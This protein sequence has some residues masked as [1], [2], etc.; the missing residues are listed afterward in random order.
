M[1][2]PRLP[3]RAAAGRADLLRIYGALGAAALE[4]AAAELHYERPAA[5]ERPAPGAAAPPQ[6]R[7][8]GGPPAGTPPPLPERPASLPRARFFRVVEHRARSAP[9]G[10]GG[11]PPPA[12]LAGAELLDGDRLPA[13]APPPRAPLMRWSRLWPFLRQA[14]G[15]RAASRRP[16]LPRLVDRLARGETLRRLPRLRQPGWS[17]EIAI[18]VDYSRS[19]RPF[20]EDFNVLL[21]A[22]EKRHGRLG[23]SCRILA[24]EPG[25][26][27]QVRRP[28][29]SASE[30][31]PLP[32]PETP[33]LIL[34][35]LGALD[36]AP[37][38]QR[39][40][41]QFGQ[42]LRR[43]GCPVLALCPLPAARH[44]GELRR[45]LT[46][47]EW[48][49][50]RRLRADA[51][52]GREA[53]PAAAVDTLLALL[54]PAVVVDV[55]LLRALRFLLPT[56]DAGGL[57]EALVWQHAD[58]LT[59]TRAGRFAGAAAIA[60]RQQQFAALPAELRQAA[61]GCLLA[62][63]A[64]LR[65]SIRLAEVST[66]GVLAPQ[67]VPPALAEEA[68]RW[69]ENIAQ[70]ASRLDAAALRQWLQRHAERQSDLALAD[71]PRLAA[72][73]ALAQRE[74]LAAGEAVA[75]PP[76]V[77][78]PEVAYF[79]QVAPAAAA[80][81]RATLCQR[82]DELWL[83]APA[84]DA[85]Q[86]GTGSPYAELTLVDGVVCVTVAQHAEAGPPAE[87]RCFAAGAL[88]RRLARLTR[89]VERF[90]LRSEHLELVVEA[91]SKPE[92]ASAVGRDAR[93]LFAEV[94]WLGR[95]RRL[96]W[97]P[98]RDGQEGRW[99]SE[100]PL[101]VDGYGLFGEIEFGGVRQRFRW[102][103]AGRFLMGSPA[104]EPQRRR[105]EVQHE[106]TL[107]E[108][109]WLADT[110]CTQALWQ[111][112]WGG[113]PSRFRD[114]PR[115]PVENV[116][117]EDAQGFVA[118]LNRRV[119]GLS[120]RLPSEAE[121]EYACRAG[122]TTPFSFGA[123]IAPE[124]VN[125]HGEYPYAG[126]RKGLFRGKTVAVASLPA[127]AWGLYE[128][129]GN[130][131]E[132][133]ADGYG[134]YASGPQVDPCAAPDGALRVLRG[135]SWYDGGWSVR[136]ARRR[137][138]GPGLRNGI[139]GFRLALGPWQAGGAGEGRAVTAEPAPETPPS[140]TGGGGVARGGTRRTAH[141]A[142]R[143][144]DFFKRR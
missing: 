134:E 72:H 49:R 102:I 65:D 41:Q 90:T 25:G 55:D 33:I 93:G 75:L 122:T 82:G 117:W 106:V 120:A 68:R 97:Q 35:D 32:P 135:G 136:S 42:R 34:S 37:E 86:A 64:G 133:C 85:P 47:V 44:A 48:D 4:Y 114:D 6:V 43:A 124:Q 29:D 66:C 127:N 105:D 73:W 74:R 24:G 63:H 57:A 129:H 58:L 116:S 100:A 1:A 8:G 87:R 76:G 36:G 107:S 9:P 115:Q 31:W 126:G 84:A 96:D 7:P 130:V 62:Q 39:G 140:G 118:E 101:G 71:D 23:L 20:H 121:W 103:V 91:L 89:E 81:R 15:R 79:L 60:A 38:T 125:Y 77:A 98:P 27:P 139:V 52:P 70:T 113:N 30:D 138:S 69:R 80:L 67:A 45:A 92:W 46:I 143:V 56:G 141:M 61:V 40:W 22:L 94:V 51:V 104:D 50:H 2:A 54:A 142:Q 119:A 132:W 110:A 78:E 3:S 108:G 131:W 18:L 17:P 137:R 99:T 11:P 95:R 83:E 59:G 12:W 112:V 21:G 128:M 109:F 13:A 53:P 16:D 26:R 14:L 88:P 10:R 5:Q 144:M 111:A 123:N 19:S 28:R